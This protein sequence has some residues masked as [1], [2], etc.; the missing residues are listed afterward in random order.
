MAGLATSARYASGARPRKCDGSKTKSATAR[1]MCTAQ[2]T[3]QRRH[4]ARTSAHAAPP[5]QFRVFLLRGPHARAT[6]RRRQVQELFRTVHTR[7]VA[8]RKATAPESWPLHRTHA[9]SHEP[10]HIPHAPPIRS[11]AEEYCSI[12]SHGERLAVWPGARGG[13]RKRH[14]EQNLGQRWAAPPTGRPET[15]SGPI[16]VSTGRHDKAKRG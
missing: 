3:D 8:W 4:S 16:V 7:R 2:R 5:A 14:G 15:E 10:V 11:L 6:A 12:S 13:L 9:A 1:R